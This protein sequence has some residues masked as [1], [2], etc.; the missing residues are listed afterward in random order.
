MLRSGP[1]DDALRQVEVHHV[2]D[3][4]E[5]AVLVVRVRPVVRVPQAVVVGRLVQLVVLHVVKAAPRVLGDLRV[6]IAPTADRDRAEVDHLQI[7]GVVVVEDH[8]R[9]QEAVH[10]RLARVV[11]R[12]EVL[13]GHERLHVLLVQ[14]H[15]R[16]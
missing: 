12:L 16:L 10:H 3:Q 1:G 15:A 4:R 13:F 9:H 2:L 5:L 8:A 11:Q 6:E 7:G 14:Q